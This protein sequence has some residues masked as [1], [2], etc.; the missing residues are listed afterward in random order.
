[1]LSQKN[2]FK[3]PEGGMICWLLL[4]TILSLLSC[5]TS[6][7]DKKFKIGFSQCTF[8]DIWRK[9]MQKEMERELSFHPEIELVV[10]DANLSSEKQKQQIQELIKDK[11]DLLIAS[12]AEA[13]PI[14]PVIDKA[15]A[16]G[17]PV[18]LVDRNTLSKN[19]TAF[20]GASNYKIGL[21][22]GAYAN[23]LLKGKGNVMEIAGKDVGSSADIG[24]HKGFTDFIKNYPDI[25]YV[26]RF[27]G[28]WDKFP[29]EWEKQFTN[30]LQ[31]HSDIQLIFGQNDRLAFAAYNVCKKLGLDEKIKIIGVDGLPGKNG[32]IDLVEK[33][34]LKATILYPTGGKEAIQTAVSILENQPYQ[35]ENELATT[36]ID[37]TNVRIM[38]LQNERVLAQQMDIDRS[39]KKIEDQAVITRNQ[40]NIIYAISIS[41]ALALIMGSVLF[42]YLRENRKIN[43]RLAL[44]NEEILMQRNQLIELGKRAKEATDAKFNFFTNI[45]HELRTPLTLILGPL[46]EILLSPK[47]HFS[48]KSQLEMVKKNSMRL[49]RLVNQLMDFRKIEEGKMKLRGS[50]NNIVEF[51]SEI[52]NAFADIADKKKISFRVDSKYKELEVWFDV[53]M[54][55]KILFNILSN[56]FKYTNDHGSIVVSLSKDSSN[57]NAII[58]IEDTGVGMGPETLE[59]AFDLFYQGNEGTYK[60]TGLGLALSKELITL[61]HGGIKIKSEKWKGTT[62]EIKLPLGKEHLE[63]SEIEKESNPYFLNYEDAK[64]YTNEAEEV[65]PFISEDL[66]HTEKDYSILIIEDNHEIRAFLKNQLDKNYEIIEAENGNVG[67][68]LAYEIVPDVIVSD[69]LLPG[70]NGMV[71]TETLKNDIRTSHIPIIILTAKGSIEQQIEGLKLKA[72]AYIVKP[73]NVQYLEETIKNLIKNRETLRDHYSSELPNESIRASSS[74]KIDRKFVSEFSAIVENNIANENF[75]VDDICREIGISRVQLYRKV[76]AVLGLNVNDY[77]LSVRMQRAKY[78]LLNEDL[79]ISEISFKVGFSSQAYF[80]TVF[81]SKFGCTPSEFKA[82]K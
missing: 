6:R 7:K 44:Q 52:T 80:S 54:L 1:M 45:S 28:D 22:A 24:R 14:A 68:N 82:K 40:T 51:I 9:T 61:H 42:F 11:I 77:I 58:T 31:S 81:K 43:A 48:V 63:Q 3:R 78:L 41:L 55:D 10:K 20:I 34:I 65:K 75:G 37:S 46:E 18:I 69:I 76:K 71:I 47:L 39:Q 49:L 5:N 62:F 13:E 72:D 67:L 57:T 59:H 12:P 79:S 66:V 8:G 29:V 70:K 60:G 15:Y 27:N 50:K 16:A 56:A 38:R 74:R 64:I 21:D 33:G 19:Y 26:L 17:I 25:N 4:I 35:K 53:N 32:G 36:I 30:V 2:I 73:F 23:A